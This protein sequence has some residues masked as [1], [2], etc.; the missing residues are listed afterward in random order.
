MADEDLQEFTGREARIPADPKG[1]KR[2]APVV[3]PSR[4]V[5]RSPAP[6]VA[7]YNP[8]AEG[9][10]HPKQARLAPALRLD[11]AEANLTSTQLELNAAF[12]HLRDC[13]RIEVAALSA[14]TRA[15]PAPSADEVIRAHVAGQHA[16]RAANVAAGIDPDAR[17]APVISKSPIDQHAMNRGKAAS[18]SGVPLRSNVVRR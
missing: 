16:I 6:S 7:V 12:T 1:G 8:P 17:A 10:S 14:F 3:V 5:D 15:M 13:E 11:E 9:E 2:V 4:S 18:R